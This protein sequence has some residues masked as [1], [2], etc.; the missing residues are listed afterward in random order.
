VEYFAMSGDTLQSIADAHNTTIEAIEKLNPNITNPNSIALNE[1]ILLPAGEPTA[2]TLSPQALPCRIFIEAPCQRTQM[3]WVQP[4][5]C[6]VLMV[7]TM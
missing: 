3:P 1:R 6:I 7:D 4:S 2:S 5:P